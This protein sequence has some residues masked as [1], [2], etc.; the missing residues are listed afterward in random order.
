MS[1]NLFSEHQ[2]YLI[3]SEIFLTC[4][5]LLMLC[6]SLF[7]NRVTY[8]YNEDFGIEMGS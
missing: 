8:V 6:R 3:K 5:E 4:T 2:D 1:E 7:G